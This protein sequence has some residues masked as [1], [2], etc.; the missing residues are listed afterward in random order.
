MDMHA[1]AVGEIYQDYA[2]PKEAM[3]D[4]KRV[5]TAAPCASRKATAWVKD[6]LPQHVD[7]AIAD[8]RLSNSREF[9][10][11]KGVC[12]RGGEKQSKGVVMRVDD[13][14]ALYCC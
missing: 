14:V 6:T 11:E 2:T 5:M 1:F 3:K 12:R 13:V 9:Y 7:R 8:G 4:A 10:L